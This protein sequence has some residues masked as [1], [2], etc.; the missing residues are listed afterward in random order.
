[1]VSNEINVCWHSYRSNIPNRFYWDT[2][3]LEDLFSGAMWR[4]ASSSRTFVHR[5]SLMDVPDTADGI[6]LVIRASG[7]IQDAHLFNRDIARFRWVLIFLTGDEDGLFNSLQLNHPNMRLWIQTPRGGVKAS[8]YLLCGY[9]TAMPE[10]R[11]KMGF[12]KRSLDWFFSGQVT[13]DRRMQCATQLRSMPQGELYETAGFTQGFP[14]QEF[15]E[16]MASAKVIPAPSGPCTP[17]SFRMVEAL[18]LGCIPIVDGQSPRHLYPEDLWP[19]VFGSIP[20][21][22][23]V[24]NWRDLRGV[25]AEQVSGWA[26]KSVVASAWWQDY[27]RTLV[28]DLERE[29]LGLQGVAMQPDNVSD[30]IT[31]VIPTSPIPAHPSTEILEKVIASIRVHLP[32][33]EIIIM[34]DGIRTGVEHRREQYTEYLQRVLWKCGHEWQSVLPVVF[35]EHSQQAAMMKKVLPKIRTPLFLF[36]EHDT[37]L[38]DKVIDW[39]AITK[40]LMSGEANTV[41]LYWFAELH[42]EHL[43]LMRERTGDFVKTIQWS[44]WPHISR[45]DFFARMLRQHFITDWPLV[46]IEKVLY[47]PV[48]GNPWD[49]YR[50]YIYCPQPDGIRFHHLNARLDQTTGVSDPCDW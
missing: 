42:P 11:K 37:T 44:S 12:P 29:I 9:P 50:T 27:K 31:V 23:I 5:N 24:Q 1:M 7:H 18:E 33:A 45:V 43:Y 16:R 46:M 17:D 32:T 39:T 47:G 38:D 10:I 48:L 3:M 34:C 41:R 15:Y 6:V 14:H 4:F 22:P 21:F 19:T 30:L 35:Q 26:E 20:P 13:N 49:E 28:H 2:A 36:C 40:L 25:V 8:R